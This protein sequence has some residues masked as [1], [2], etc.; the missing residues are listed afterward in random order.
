[1]NRPIFFSFNSIKKVFLVFSLIFL[2]L[3]GS[4]YISC[5]SEAQSNAATLQKFNR[6]W[7]TYPAIVE[8]DT[9]HDLFVIGDIHGDYEGLLELLIASDIISEIPPEPSNVKWNAGNS[10]LVI[11]GD[12][13]SKGSN[14]VNVLI[15]LRELQQS[16]SRAGGHVILTFGNHEAEF[17][18]D[19]KEEKVKM[20]R[21]ELKGL[22]ISSK[23]VAKGMDSLGIGIFMQNLPFAARV[24]DWFFIHAGHPNKYT[25]KELESKIIAGID[26]DGFG[27]PILLDEKEGILEVRMDPRPWWEKKKDNGK[28]SKDRLEEILNVLGVKHIVVGHQP[29]KYSF[30]DGDTRK[31]GKMYQKFDGMIFFIDMG[32]EGKK[33]DGAVLHIQKVDEREV[34]IAIYPENKK[35][36]WLWPKE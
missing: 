19:P 34:A 16:A 7:S 14:S 36:K 13:V 4:S 2:T 21:K 27:A 31:K 9:N 15:L 24:N 35:K 10:T 1:M 3:F 17:L 29:G 33:S 18:N 25:L 32:M 5:Q 6:D 8:I 20:F 22:D 30:A 26:K 28:E 12:M 23:D 11:P